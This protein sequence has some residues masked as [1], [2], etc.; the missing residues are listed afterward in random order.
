MWVDLNLE[1]GNFDPFNLQ[2]WLNALRT[3][4]NLYYLLKF[5][6]FLTENSL[7]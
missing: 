1:S 6:F 5:S 2:T 4:T 7:I 3:D